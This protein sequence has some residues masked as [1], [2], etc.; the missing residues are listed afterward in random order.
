METSKEQ[1]RS[2]KTLYFTE[3]D[4]LSDDFFAPCLNSFLSYDRAA[5]YFSSSALRHWAANVI[6]L[7]NDESASIRLLIS[8]KISN[9]DYDAFRDAISEEKK[10]EILADG[11]DQ[12]L[13]K[14]ILWETGEVEP[15]EKEFGKILAWLIAKAKLEV[16]FAFNLSEGSEAGIFHKKIGIFTFPWGDMVAFTGSANETHSGHSVNSESIDVYRSWD[17]HDKER[18]QGK[19][20]EFSASW[21]PDPSKLL[22]LKLSEPVLDII[23]NY[24]HDNPPNISF[25]KKLRTTA[26]PPQTGF[27][28]SDLWP[29]QAKAFETFL[30]SK[31]GVLEMATGTGKTRT[32]IAILS[33]L[34]CKREIEAVVVTMT[35]NDL[36]TQWEGDLRTSLTSKLG[37]TLLTTLGGK[38]G[39]EHFVMNPRGKVLLCSRAKLAKVI[40]VFRR[41]DPGIPIAIVHDEVH[42]LGSPANVRDLQGHKNFFAFRLGLS[43]TPER[44]YDDTGNQFVESEVGP[45]LYSYTLETAIEDG[46]LCPLDYFCIPYRLTLDDRSDVKNVY[47]RRSAAAAS[48]NPWTDER[49]WME[50]SRVYKKAREKPSAFASFI[51]NHEDMAFLESTIVFVEDKEFGERLYDTLIRHTNRYS[52]YFDSDDSSVL[53]RFARGDLDCLVTCHKISQGID[54]PSLRNVVLFSSSKSRRETI[55]RL[56]RCLRSDPGN[57]QKIASV[58]DFVVTDQAGS[59]VADSIDTD[60]VEWLTRLAK[61]RRKSGGPS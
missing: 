9:E 28:L 52:Q 53:K 13:A 11:G 19:I 14:A 51:K 60:R 10:R 23:R 45:V 49:L 39:E 34:Y 22:V 29:N 12:F 56:G 37:L 15:K 47:A 55:Q 59:P 8:P 40:E 5:G 21:N 57:P 25:L 27:P 7:T 48:G 18:I 4:N 46:I 50:L 1:I 2:L 32:A 58:I 41:L 3:R 17:P 31:C 20:E 61:V 42:D 44:A 54:V 26:V 33:H 38:S 43:A 24:S 6:R 30:A 16:Q 36:L 35:G